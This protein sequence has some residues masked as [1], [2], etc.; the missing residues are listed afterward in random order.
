[1]GFRVN[2]DRVAHVVDAEAMVA[3]G[4]G[5][6]CRL[7]VCHRLDNGT[8]DGVC[9]QLIPGIVDGKD[10]AGAMVIVSRPEEDLS[11]LPV[12]GEYF[13]C[14]FDYL[15]AVFSGDEIDVGGKR[16]MRFSPA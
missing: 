13:S 4:D 2:D 15:F 6:V 1:M 3:R 10:G 5:K 11:S 14:P 16:M 12:F 8:D 9:S 7:N